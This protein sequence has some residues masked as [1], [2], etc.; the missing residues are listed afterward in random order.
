MALTDIQVKKATFDNSKKVTK[1][2]DEKGMFLQVMKNGSKYFKFQY[3]F[4]GKQKQ[5]SL[6]VYPETSLKE[7]REKRDEAR[8]MVS[9]GIN[10]SEV[11]KLNKQNL[12][13]DLANN[14]Q[15]VASEWYVKY[16]SKWTPKHAERKWRSLEKDV[17]PYIGKMP[18]RSITPQDILKVLNRIQDRGAIET[19]HRV[20]TIC[21]EVFRYGV[22]INKCERDYTLDLKGALLSPKTKHMACI[23]DPK[24][25]GDLLKAID[26]YEGEFVTRCAL[27]L[28]P[29]VFARPGELRQA[30]WSEIDF[31]KKHWRIPA[32]KMKMR[33]EH[34]IPL[35]K[36]AIEILKDIEPV[37]GRW[38]YV[39]PSILSK[40]RPMSNNTINTALRRMGYT[41]DEVT[42]HGFRGTAS[43]LLYENGF[44][45][46][47]IET[48]LAHTEQNKVKAAY[49][50]AKYIE[51]RTRMMQW[52]ADYL[53]EL[54]NNI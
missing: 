11:R 12:I 26:N 46:A 41:N 3:Y 18:I 9:N 45:E 53:D 43:T 25:L 1:I 23:K 33:R 7:A 32:Y 49:N 50:H 27:K 31:E 15:S 34:I 30:E 44:K 36:Q 47:H 8:K 39:F 22:I 4:A 10:P 29:V 17:L 13:D 48:Q 2:F 40:D 52:W 35:S 20:K 42:A 16:K 28:T 54:K 14:F 5:I 6:G 19:A 37:T 51:E 24:K 21:G 38:K